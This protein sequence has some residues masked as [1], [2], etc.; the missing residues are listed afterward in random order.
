MLALTRFVL[1]HRAPV[2]VAWVA[3]LAASTFA[4]REL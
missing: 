1:R 2:L 3:V 4:V